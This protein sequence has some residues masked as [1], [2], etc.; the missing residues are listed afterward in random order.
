MNPRGFDDIL[1]S[2]NAALRDRAG[3]FLRKMNVPLDLAA[4][5]AQ[6]SF[7]LKDSA[8]EML[9]FGAGLFPADGDA[10]SPEIDDCRVP[11]LV[12]N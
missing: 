8:R 11:S 9:F 12:E 6:S 7:D 4:Y 1:E 5:D 10:A 2:L 3:D